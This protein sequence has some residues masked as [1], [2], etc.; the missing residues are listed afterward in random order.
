MPYKNAWTH[1]NDAVSGVF[2]TCHFLSG[3][4]MLR[5]DS[6]PAGTPRSEDVRA[7]RLRLF[8][9]LQ[10]AEPS[11]DY[12]RALTHG[13]PKDWKRPLKALQSTVFWRLGTTV[14]PVN[15]AEPIEMLFGGQTRVGPGN[16]VFDVVHI[17][18]TWRMRL[19]DR[20]WRRCVHMLAYFDH[21]LMML[22]TSRRCY[23]G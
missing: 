11:T 22:S 15:T 20:T 6:G 19:K 14:R 17:G 3:V 8:G 23:A 5:S 13:P 21:L 7:R 12:A 10:R 2:A 16:N 1:L 9:H 18:A 4:R